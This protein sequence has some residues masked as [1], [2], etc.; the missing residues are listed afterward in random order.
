[1]GAAASAARDHRDFGRPW[2]NK[3]SD[4]VA[5]SP[6]CRA[7]VEADV[8]MRRVLEISEIKVTVGMP[9]SARPLTASL[10]AGP[11]SVIV[12]IL[13]AIAHSTTSKSIKNRV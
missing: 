2:A 9:R 7:V 12:E 1:M 11:C 8:A 3:P 10:T 4:E 13:V 6:A 5:R